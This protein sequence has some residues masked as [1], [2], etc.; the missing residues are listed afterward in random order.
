MVS[1]A[2]LSAQRST[3]AND[4]K[5]RA[6]CRLAART[7]ETGHPSTHYEWAVNEIRRC[8]Q[9]ASPPTRPAAWARL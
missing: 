1:A 4:A 3:E 5:L 6:N 8:E 9:S 7:L 2:P